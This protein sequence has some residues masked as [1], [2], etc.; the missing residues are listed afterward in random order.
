MYRI[1]YRFLVPGWSAK[2]LVIAHDRIMGTH[3]ELAG[4]WGTHAQIAA[5]GTPTELCEAPV[6]SHQHNVKRMTMADHDHAQFTRRSF[7]SNVAQ[8]AAW[9]CAAMPV[10]SSCCRWVGTTT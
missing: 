3:R 6:I 7:R 2:P 9:W 8:T 10:M 5:Y 1:S 4:R